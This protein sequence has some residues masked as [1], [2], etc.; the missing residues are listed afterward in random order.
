[1]QDV[2]DTVIVQALAA[3]PSALVHFNRDAAAAE[4]TTLA[5]MPNVAVPELPEAHVRLTSC[6]GFKG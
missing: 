1:M 4:A 6:N 5:L 3:V 2:L